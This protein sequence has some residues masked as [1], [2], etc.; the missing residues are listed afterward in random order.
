LC[1][2]VNNNGKNREKQEKHPRRAMSA[3][4]KQQQTRLRT[5]I[6]ACRGKSGGKLGKSRN[7]ECR[8]LQSLNKHKNN[9]NSFKV[10]P[11]TKHRC[12]KVGKNLQRRS[13][14]DD[15]KLCAWVSSLKV[16]LKEIFYK[17]L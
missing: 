2:A 5:G 7:R 11:K 4:I 16:F 9:I 17:F 3:R 6:H 10:K 1:A 14:N 12:E 15:T 13:E 8:Q